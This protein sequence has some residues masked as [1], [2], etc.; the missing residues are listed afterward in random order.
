MYE[1]KDHLL[2]IVGRG[3]GCIAKETD[4]GEEE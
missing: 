3:K 2:G 1:M 4:E